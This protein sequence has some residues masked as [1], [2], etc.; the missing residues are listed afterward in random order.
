MTPSVI[1]NAQSAIVAI[2][3]NATI[4]DALT[5][6]KPT[7]LIP[8]KTEICEALRRLSS[9]NVAEVL[10]SEAATSEAISNWLHKDAFNERSSSK[11]HIDFKGLS[12]LPNLLGALLTS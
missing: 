6:D 12:R 2:G 5:S 9:F 7:L 10:D 8:S 1:F 4:S 11:D 3:N